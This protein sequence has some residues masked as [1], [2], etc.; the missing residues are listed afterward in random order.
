[1]LILY[2]MP[3]IWVMSLPFY[4]HTYIIGHYNP[5]VRIFGLVSHTTHV[6]C[7]KFYTWAAG[8]SVQCRLRMKNFLRN[9]FMARLFTLRVLARNLLR[10]NRRSD[11]FFFHIS[12]W[13]LTWDS[14]PIL[15]F[16]KPTHYLR[17]YG[18][19][20]T[21]SFCLPKFRSQL[22]GNCPLKTAN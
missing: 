18:E 13:C 11:I 10:G 6:V 2:N 7:V 5:S 15:K 3:T 8:P 9:F 20:I 14:N 21:H 17:V 12:L 19:L 16:N 1:M 4:I 22:L